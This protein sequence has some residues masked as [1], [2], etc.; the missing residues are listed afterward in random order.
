M[1]KQPKAEAAD[2]PKAETSR[3]ANLGE[4]LAV[5]EPIGRS[6]VRNLLWLTPSW[7][8]SMI[9]HVVVLLALALISLPPGTVEELRQLVV[10]PNQN[11][12]LEE[13]EDFDDEPLEEL[14]LSV[15]DAVSFDSQVTENIDISVFDEPAAIVSVELSDLG[16]THAPRQ[17]LLTT[18]GAFSGHA[19][20]GRGKGKASLVAQGGGSEASERAVALGLKWLVNH[21]FPDGSWSFN[22]AA[23]PKCRAEC[24][25]PGSL[26]NARNGA[27]AMAL[28]PFLG[29]GQTHNAGIYKSQ[30]KGGLAY[31]VSKMKVDPQMGGSLYEG[32]GSM[33]SHGLAA[34]ALCEAY[35]MTRDKGLQAPAQ[36]AIKFICNAQDPVGGGWRYK[37]RQAGDTSAVGWQVMALKSG[38]MAYL[39]VP[40]LIVQRAY[41]YLD[42]VQAN[43]GANY[44][45]ATPGTGQAT[46]AIG[47]LCRMYF[48]WDKE[49]PALKRGVDWISR[50]GPSANNVY[51]NYYATQVMRHYEGELWE[52]WNTVMRDQLI[53]SQST[54]GH[55]EGSWPAEGGAHAKGGRLYETAMSIM[56]LEV[57]YRHLPIYRKESTTEKFPLD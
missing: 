47:L 22:H 28:L 24:R 38:H 34:I 50:Q 39:Q 56:V 49:H 33:Y 5:A 27:T 51:Y 18:V 41:K 44:G 55:Q 12:E 35:A 25:N 8:I 13:L 17:D 32:G 46:T 45:Y 48:G 20:S 3:T 54:K 36:Q 10:S 40:P 26:D 7:M 30:V 2:Q 19:M 52:K 16:L 23:A 14:D 43:N 15:V 4:A 11:N 37:P 6:W 53:R 9:V 31:L 57:Y 1:A 29:A 21:Q 42:T